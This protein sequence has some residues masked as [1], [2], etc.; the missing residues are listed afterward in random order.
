MAKLTSLMPRFSIALQVTAFVALLSMDARRTAAGY[1]DT[2][3]CL[4]LTS[5]HPATDSHRN[6][7]DADSESQATT[8]SPPPA[9]EAASSSRADHANESSSDRVSMPADESSPIRRRG[10]AAEATAE[11][12][13]GQNGHARASEAEASST[14]AW[15]VGEAL[16]WY[17]ARVHAP[18]LRQPLVQVWERAM[19]CAL[20]ILI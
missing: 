16:R 18:L 19:H 9:A 14:G 12:A 20:G 7:L 15:G 13:A 1:A 8:S 10:P 17:M 11:A 3:P 4:Q 6:Q 5:E 2:I